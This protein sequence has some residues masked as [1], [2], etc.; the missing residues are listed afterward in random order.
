MPVPIRNN[1]LYFTRKERR[2]SLLLLILI[3]LLCA[4]PFVLPFFMKDQVVEKE[5]VQQSS[6]SLNTQQQS[7]KTKNNYSSNENQYYR[8]YDEPKEYS[9][10]NNTIISET[11]FYFDPNTLDEAGWKKIGLSNKTIATILN[12]ISKGGKFREA[13]DI[14]KIWGLKADDAE[15]LIPYIQIAATEQAHSNKSFNH[16]FERKASTP[17]TY[18]IV[19]INEADTTELIS[20]PGIGS[21]LSQ[22]IIN[23]RNRLGGFY[24]VEQVAE[25]FALPDS[26][27]QKIKPLLQVSGAVKTININAANVNEL[28]QHP[29]IKYSL[30]NAIVQFRTQHGNF[31]HVNELK[32]IMIVDEGLYQKLLPYLAVQ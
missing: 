25:T 11:L 6:A 28:K 4:T 3:F 8:P 14:K 12:Y 27:Y 16:S 31:T 18:S 29:Y 24:R 30:A 20:L 2:G 9:T 23:F 10:K 26:T 22:R 5:I 21:K 7:A 17:K 13:S 32:K 15:K 1:Y 19:N